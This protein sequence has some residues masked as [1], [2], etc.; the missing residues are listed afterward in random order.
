MSDSTIPTHPT[1]SPAPGEEDHGLVARI[2]R[3]DP[4]L[5]PQLVVA[6]AILLQL[7]LPE[8]VTI[9]PS[10]LLP[11]L[12]TL[13]LIGLIATAPHKTIGRRTPIRRNIAMALI[14]FV[15]AANIVSLVLLCRLLVN[16]SKE[17]GRNLILA[18]VVLWVTNVL[19]FSLWYWEL[20]RG[21]PLARASEPDQP[22]F[23]FPQ[24]VTPELAPGWEPNL[25]D[26]LYVSFTN[27][28]AFSPTDAMPLS[29][30]AKS[31]MALQSLASLVTVGLVVAR[32]V[33]I[34]QG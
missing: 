7:S 30:G 15:S 22:D 19:L 11:A 24:M 13:L 2:L 6:A 12:E 17:S 9:G 8:R 5:G 31:L 23:Q 3:W 20:D 27:A 14:G 26:Y 1:D 4:Y 25:I 34:L 21:G 18:G 32:A 10:W 33:N 16:G 29:R 28:T